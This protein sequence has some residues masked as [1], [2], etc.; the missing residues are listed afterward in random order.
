MR[1]SCIALSIALVAATLGCGRATSEKPGDADRSE[2]PAPSTGG[3]CPPALWIESEGDDLIRTATAVG[4]CTV[5]PCPAE[6]ADGCV[7]LAGT[8]S[9]SG[10]CVLDLVSVAGATEHHVIMVDELVA[11]SGCGGLMSY[12]KSGAVS[13]LAFSQRTPTFA[14]D[15]TCLCPADRTCFPNAKCAPDRSKA[16]CLKMPKSCGEMLPR[17]V[18]GCDGEVYENF[19]LAHLA[20]AESVDAKHCTLGPDRF[21]CG[22]EICRAPDQ[23]CRLIY[24]D[25]TKHESGECRFN[26]GCRKYPGAKCDCDGIPNCSCATDAQGFTTCRIPTDI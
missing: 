6:R 25:V 17:P 18:C 1:A 26:G 15:G 24:S 11:V 13:I 12:P 8:F 23:L 10:R 19:C 21:A 2:S 16:Q 7:V 22:R 9:G 4:P 5:D 20:G 14:A 3:A